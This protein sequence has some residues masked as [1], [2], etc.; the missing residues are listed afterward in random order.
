[1]PTERGYATTCRTFAIETGV[2]RQ[3]RLLHRVKKGVRM[4]TLNGRETIEEIY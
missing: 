4:G 1:M 2:I 3:L